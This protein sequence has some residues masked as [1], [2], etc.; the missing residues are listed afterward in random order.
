MKKAAKPAKT[1]TSPYSHRTYTAEDVK[2]LRDARNAVSDL[3]SW[4]DTKEGDD[5]WFNVYERL[6][7]I[8]SNIEARLGTEGDKL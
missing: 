7:E 4:E 1:W 3:F 5:F 6:D 8:A 2:Q